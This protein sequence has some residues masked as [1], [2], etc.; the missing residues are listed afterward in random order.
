MTHEGVTRG[1]TQEKAGQS[2]GAGTAHRARRWHATTM[3]LAILA[4]MFMGLA[5]TG[6][7]AQAAPPPSDDRL[8]DQPSGWWMY[9]NLDATTL[10]DKL[11]ENKARLTDLRVNSASPLTFTA[12][13]VPASGPYGTGYWW[14]Y[15]RT[16]AQVDSLLATNNARPIS[17]QK[18]WTGSAWR[19]AVV[20]VPNTGADYRPWKIAEGTPS[21]ISSAL[22]AFG[23]SRLA[24][25]SVN[26]GDSTFSNYTAIIVSNAN[27]Y[28]WWWY[29]SLTADGVASVLTSTGGRLVDLDPHGNGTFSV[30]IYAMPGQY[31][32]HYGQ[33]AKQLLDLATQHGARMIDVTPYN[34]GGTVRYA[35]VM[36]NNLTG[37][38][39]QLRD[40]FDGKTAG[41]SFGFRLQQVGGPVLAGLQT[42]KQFE[43]ASSIKALYHLHTLIARQ[44]GLSDSTT[45]AYR[46]NDFSQTNSSEA[47]ICPDNALY[48]NSTDMKNAEEQMMWNSD[49]RMTKAITDRFG[50]PA[51]SSTG[52][53]I[54]MTKTVLQHDDG[55]PTATTH[56]YTTL[57]DLAKVYEAGFTRT[58][59]DQVLDTTHRGLFHTRMLN[60]FNTNMFG[61]AANPN[62]GICD[63]VDQEAGKL[64][65]S[66][67]EGSFCLNIIYMVK[68][69]SYDYGTGVEAGLGTRS[70]GRLLGLPTKSGAVINRTFYTYGDFV[71]N[72]TDTAANSASIGSLRTQAFLDAIRPLINQALQT[73]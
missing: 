20:M 54:G 5:F 49:N 57:D 9:N 34:S 21:A 7:A 69:G 2:A 10:S 27:G 50:Y 64:G 44:G 31:W 55:C 32:W 23:D 39:A 33:T 48:L 37:P 61:T 28:G 11:T 14:Y 67:Q 46:T 71:D 66:S 16:R 36:V 60:E 6:T 19:Y 73:W 22:T 70:A 15:D 65:K 59:S 63:V 12:T 17:L 45:L 68:G 18:Y 4:A 35:G 25:L 8:G 47:G 43:P 13:M 29:P 26:V 56:N 24:G 42:D 58:G 51:I 30:I 38:S 40:E 62:D 53:K 52:T 3:V 1:V 41:G 72:F